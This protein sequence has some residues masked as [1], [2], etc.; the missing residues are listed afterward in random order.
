[1]RLKPGLT[2]AQLTTAL[3]ARVACQIGTTCSTLHAEWDQVFPTGISD[4][5]RGEPVA[6]SGFL[7]VS[8]LCAQPFRES[9]AVR[10][11][12]AYRIGTH[13]PTLHTK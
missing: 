11:I 9:H 4:G 3:E 12:D 6:A 7:G 13:C 2:D 8:C 1:V 5:A 10:P